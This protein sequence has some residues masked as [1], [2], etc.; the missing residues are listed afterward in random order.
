MGG[1]VSIYSPISAG[2]DVPAVADVADQFQRFV[3]C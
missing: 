2:K 1:S 3:L